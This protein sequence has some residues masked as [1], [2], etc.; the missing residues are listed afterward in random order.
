MGAPAAIVG[1]S[2]LREG[3]NSCM[4]IRHEK[5][6]YVCVCV[7]MFI[8]ECV[9]TKCT[10]IHMCIHMYIYIYICTCAFLF[11]YIYTCMHTLIYDFLIVR[12]TYAHGPL[13]LNEVGALDGRYFVHGTH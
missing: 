9:H 13:N 2:I 11:M 7:H 12:V 6:M 8:F 1:A 4:W 10:Y 5:P 3:V